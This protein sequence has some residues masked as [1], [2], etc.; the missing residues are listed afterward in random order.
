[1]TMTIFTSK[2]SMSSILS[3][4]NGLRNSS[5]LPVAA[6]Q[7]IKEIP[8]ELSHVFQIPKH[9]P[10]METRRTLIEDKHRCTLQPID[11]DIV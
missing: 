5:R 8:K 4:M 3:D 2:E 7:I 9:N 11:E 6:N 10:N 1:M